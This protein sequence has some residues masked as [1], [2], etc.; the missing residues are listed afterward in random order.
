M[1]VVCRVAS[2]RTAT[3]RPVAAA[4]R[5]ARRC[6]L[7]CWCLAASGCH[8][9]YHE[10]N[11]VISDAVRTVIREPKIFPLQKNDYVERIRDRFLARKAW[12]DMLATNP[13]QDYSGDY[14][15]GFKDGFAD[16]LYEG[17]TGEP[18]DLPPR[19]YWRIGYQTP[20]GRQAIGEYFGGFRHGVAVC[21]ASSLR[22]YATVPSATQ[23]SSVC[24]DPQ[25]S[26]G[27]P[28]AETL[29][30]DRQFEQV[31]PPPGV[32]IEPS[33]SEFEVTR[34]K[35]RSINRLRPKPHSTGPRMAQPASV[36]PTGPP[37]RP[38]K[39]VATPPD[40]TGG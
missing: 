3:G 11:G 15:R 16:Y 17:G 4:V 18:P 34:A 22:Q 28:A 1:T 19:H 38:A 30:S 9:V 33:L 20:A 12:A 29:E 39:H 6:L 14:C 40:P 21:Q 35:S 13:G 5:V 8:L 31:L 7:V 27:G 25:P 37:L 32:P 10:R 2:D 23:F 26:V 36:Q 24:A